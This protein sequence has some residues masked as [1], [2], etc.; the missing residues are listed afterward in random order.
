MA[1]GGAMAIEDGAVFAR[2]FLQEKDT[3]Q[4]LQL[5]QRNR[6]QRTAR[7][8]NE[9]SANRQMFHLPSGEA[10]REAFANRDMNAER[11]D[12]LFSYDPTTVAL[13]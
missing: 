5:Y 2:A 8:V 9:S 4:A 13:N 1:Q 7:I 10:L 6:L 3:G 12:W 11:N